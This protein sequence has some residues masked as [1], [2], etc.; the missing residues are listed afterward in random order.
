M[1]KIKLTLAFLC[2]AVFSALP[3]L[4]DNYQYLWNKTTA[5][6]ETVTD[7]PSLP[8][9]GV[10]YADI[11]FVLQSN[12]KDFF[13]F[14]GYEKDYCSAYAGEACS[15]EHAIVEITGCNARV[16]AADRHLRVDLDS[17]IYNWLTPFGMA[18]KNK[19][20]VDLMRTDHSS[21]DRTTFAV[22]GAT[23]Y[24]PTVRF[25]GSAL[26]EDLFVL[27]GGTHTIGGEFI[28][29]Y[30]YANF[31]GSTASTYRFDVTNKA[32]VTLD[33][34]MQ[35]GNDSPA[36][37]YGSTK[38]KDIYFTVTDGSTLT[39]N[40]NVSQAAGGHHH[41]LI[42]DSTVVNGEKF[43][44]G[45]Q[46]TTAAANITTDTLIT[47]STYQSAGLNVHSGSVRFMDSILDTS[48]GFIHL[49]W[50]AG[51]QTSLDL[52]NCQTAF[53]NTNNWH[54]WPRSTGSCDLN[55]SGGA[56][57]V[58]SAYAAGEL[59]DN[60]TGTVT[61]AENATVT[62]A[63]LRLGARW[64]GLGTLNVRSGTTTIT[65]LE[66]GARNNNGS[67]VGGVGVVNVSGGTLKSAGMVMGNSAV[68]SHASYPSYLG[69][70]LVHVTG[71]VF[72]DTATGSGSVHSF[73]VCDNASARPSRVAL[74]GGEMRVNKL[75]GGAGAQVNG[76][77]SWAAFEADGGKLVPPF[78]ASTLLY[79][80]DEATL[81][82][83]GLTVVSDSGCTIAQSFVD[84]NG[85][86][87]R[88]IL[89]G[90]GVK[91]L[92]GDQSGL[93]EVV[94]RGGT[95]D[96][97]AAPLGGLTLDGGV[98]A[99][100]SSQAITVGGDLTVI[101]AR[102]ALDA[103]FTLGTT[104]PIL[105]V[106]GMISDASK[107]ALEGA[108]AAS[109]LAD[110]LAFDLSYDT[111]SDPGRTLVK[112]TIREAVTLVAEATEGKVVDSTNRAY[113]AVDTLRATAA[114]GA[115][116]TLTG[117]LGRGNFEKRGAGVVTL[118]N[119][120]NRFIGSVVL[121][122]GKLSVSSLLALGYDE[123][124]DGTFTIKDG[125][126]QFADPAEESRFPYGLVVDTASGTAAVI[127]KTDTNLVVDNYTLTSGTFIKRGAGDLILEASGTKP[128]AIGNGNSAAATSFPQTEIVFDGN[129]TVPDCYHGGVTVAEGALVLRGLTDD[130][131]FTA[132]YNLYFG[133]P[134]KDGSVQP[135]LVID[136]AKLN[137]TAKG[138]KAFGVGC[139]LG[140]DNTFVTSARVVL[141]NEAYLEANT[142]SI[143]SG[144][145]A[146]AVQN[147]S[148]IADGSTIVCGYQFAANSGGRK[149]C[150]ASHLFK[151]GSKLYSSVSWGGVGSMTF[152]NS[153]L[154]LNEALE[155]IT[156]WVNN[157]SPSLVFQNGSLFCCKDIARSAG[158]GI[159]GGDSSFTFDDSEWRPS[160][161]GDFDFNTLRVGAN[162]KFFSSGRGLILS[163]A[164]GAT[165][166]FGKIIL[167]GTGGLVKRGEGTL[168]MP[169]AN[170]AAT[171]EIAVEAGTLDLSGTTATGRTFSGS[172]AIRN[173]TL[174]NP[175]IKVTQGGTGLDL[176]AITPTGRVYMDFSEY[177]DGV[178]LGTAIP[179][180]R[181]SGTIDLSKWRG[182]NL[183][184]TGV[185][186]TFA[187][188]NGVVLATV[189]YAGL[190]LLLR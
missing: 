180:A 173:G 73:V 102:F 165:Y 116:L 34:A 141:T 3:A 182:R 153:L 43:L 123:F 128:L 179:V 187:V 48:S 125:T 67:I 97:T 136:H 7:W 99:L 117:Q 85:A 50:F 12:G 114:S 57:S 37:L 87:G 101:A 76:G 129:G 178:P 168:V 22:H 127:L 21:F 131:V 108:R 52:I 150:S 56:F 45:P 111:E 27:D 122:E 109:G 149:T 55:I 26:V 94:V 71:G 41:I 86:K 42:A 115:S 163:P 96:V 158:D 190:L 146:D 113:T 1:N 24:W 133:I 83:R 72:A 124:G 119:E 126:F 152:D 47:N 147:T 91:T 54:E 140:P 88:L 181:V 171:G 169:M 159:A 66:I 4:A 75:Y 25:A 134:T 160:A 58:S 18:W 31:Y 161:T 11:P 145:N 132:P 186:A 154:A 51:A 32:S 79:G 164:A 100:S 9:N 29:P 105:A 92:T 175:V 30:R 74:D 53:R 33:G 156:M 162:T 61:V 70:N 143:N 6:E 15:N 59:A 130:A 148:F 16:S 184:V 44:F 17:G 139:G 98:L 89:D 95:T 5:E 176:G 107:A 106:S 8:S 35:M 157:E 144:C 81:G 84:A 170:L 93:S 65:S 142:V 60:A 46:T 155:P 151:N 49:G 63:T 185:K 90:A 40:A 69:T 104:K 120:A 39:L 172:G 2:I 189:D 62:I 183:G 14:F 78:A 28:M 177:G 36:G 80:F 19:P 167:K 138:S 112:M 188:Q 20:A 10:N 82:E 110:G 38:D 13:R 64:G 77:S 68:V 135:S 121:Y 23:T 103:G 174:E 166:T 118:V 137:Q